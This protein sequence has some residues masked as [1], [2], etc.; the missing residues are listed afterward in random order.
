MALLASTSSTQPPV[1]WIRIFA[2]LFAQRRSDIGADA[3]VR[4][5]IREFRVSGHLQ[6]EHAAA[7]VQGPRGAA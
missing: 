1:E 2:A 6:P 4:L 5:A 3:V 7:H